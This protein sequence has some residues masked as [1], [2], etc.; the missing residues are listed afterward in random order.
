M[1]DKT[2]I[3]WCDATWNTVVGCS[4]TSPGCREC[5]AEKLLSTRMKHMPIYGDVTEGGKWTGKTG[6]LPHRLD[7]PLRWKRPRKI[8]VNDL[9]DTFHETV[10]FEFIAAL[11]GVMAACPQHTFQVLTK[12]PERMLALLST[13]E[14]HECLAAFLGFELHEQCGWRGDIAAKAMG[15]RWEPPQIGDEGRVELAG[16]YDVPSLAWPLPNVWLGVTCEDQQRAN[17][18]IPLL[19]QCPAAVRFVSAEPLLEAIDF[20]QAQD[21]PGVCRVSEYSS[22][23]TAFGSLDRAIIG[24]ES[25]PRARPCDVDWIR[26]IRGQCKTAGV[27]CFVKQLGARIRW[28]KYGGDGGT[29]HESRCAGGIA[30]HAGADPAEWPEDLRVRE[31]PE[32]S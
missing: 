1:G 4:K 14:F 21:P 30:H 31:Y 8:F 18:R 5:Y 28:G 32:A 9:G 12:R 7:Q 2:K 17:E 22:R 24:G 16:Y 25:G 11:F 27:A 6:L 15:G 29:A 20:F 19:L 13:A 26:S 3:A 10:P 23:N